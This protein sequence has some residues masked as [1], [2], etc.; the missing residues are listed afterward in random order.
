[1][2]GQRISLD[3]TWHF[4]TD[5]DDV[6][7]R[8][9]WY[10]QPIEATRWD[11]VRVPGW[12]EQ[13]GRDGDEGVGWYRR[14]FDFRVRRV[15]DPTDSAGRQR[16]GLCLAGIN[17]AATVWINGV[18][19]ASESPNRY[20]FAG[21]IDRVARPGKN[22]IV[23]H[24]PDRGVPGG[25][26]LG[27]WIGSYRRIEEL[28]PGQHAAASARSSPDWVRDAV[29]YEV[30]LRS[31]SPDGTFGSL[32]ERLDE[33]R[34]L[35][36]TVIWLMP[37]HPIGK[38]YRK[39]SLGSPYAVADYYAI[40]PELGTRDE[41][42]AL[43]DA[44]H[45]RGMRL[46]I[47]LVANHT[48]WDNPLVDD[49]PEWFARDQ[50]GDIRSPF[51]D[52]HDV[53][54]L[55]YDA[56]ELRRYMT[57]MMLYWVR[58]FGIDGFRCDVAG[59]VPTDFWN[60]ARAKLD[61]VR[62]IMVLA[63]DDQPVQHLHAFDLTY[64]WW[65]YQALGRLRAGKLRSASIAAILANAELDFPAGSLRLRFSSNHDL[66]A[67][68][69]P[70]MERYSLDAAK[71]AAV[72]TY[73]L[74]GVPLIYNGQ[75]AG[76]RT[77]LPLFERVPIDWRQTDDCDLPGLYAYLGRLRRQRRS[78]RRGDTQILPALAELNVLGIRRTWQD[79]TTCVLVNCSD[80]PWEIDIGDVLPTPAT[81][82]LGMTTTRRIGSKRAIELP[83][84][85]YW[86]GT[87]P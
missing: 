48:A 13:H 5:L 68:H 6:G 47:D 26:L 65:T 73:A 70:G 7:L 60:D 15:I 86:I 9:E 29:I 42:K 56:A 46:I 45:E 63:E 77:R 1:M 57:A 19:V 24:V 84:L 23:I 52:W 81:T 38:A 61:A 14:E 10:R 12:W 50:H 83:A 21:N 76:N 85:G 51:G 80:E 20:R 79:E 87:T 32:Q 43:L 17:D 69:Q 64:D 78:L 39:G 33:L 34:Q 67:W 8:D 82:L 35:G 25:I 31:F 59:M 74:P 54:Q 27:A 11:T 41:F 3:G 44:V 16:L 75:E 37:I 2:S 28:L 36:V 4:K 72:L 49:H 18:E 55:D 58:N 71:T 66:C 53:A 62:P 22:T 30:Y 40:N